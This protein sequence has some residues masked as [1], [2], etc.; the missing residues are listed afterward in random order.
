MDVRDLAL[1]VEVS[2]Y[3]VQFWFK[4]CTLKGDILLVPNQ[5]VGRFIANCWGPQMRAIIPNLT[6][7]V[8]P[9]QEKAKPSQLNAKGR[10]W[11]AERKAE[12]SRLDMD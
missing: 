3:D 4:D 9:P 11:E 1:K 8:Q 7:R 5:S 2:N 6:I 10:K 12:Q